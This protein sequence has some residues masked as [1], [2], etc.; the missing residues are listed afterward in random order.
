MTETIRAIA[1]FSGGLD[2]T[3]AVRVVRDQGIHVHALRFQTGFC[4]SDDRGR[5][6]ANPGEIYR[7]DAAAGGERLGVP[8]EVIDIYEEYWDILTS[9]PH[10]YGSMMNP[11]I[12]CRIHMLRVAKEKMAER[13]AR[14]VFTGEVLGQRPMTQQRRTLRLIEKESGLDGLLLRPLSAK[15]LEPTLPEKEG[16]IDREKLFDFSGRGRKGQMRLA[17]E[18]G[19]EEYPAPAGGCCSLLDPV[20]AARLTDL[21]ERLGPDERLAREEVHLLKVGRHFR[22]SPSAKLI[23]ARDEGECRVVHF[24]GRLGWRLEAVDVRGPV[25]LVQGE[26][27]ETDLLTAAGI[28]ASYGDGKRAPAVRVRIERGGVS[29]EVEAA[30]LSREI[31]ASLRIE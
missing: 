3:L 21:L 27:S 28:T 6:H 26:P 5:K 16:W 30:P 7:T 15:L 13:D 18:L 10:G 11:C 31:S 25:A 23:V 2:S 24:H 9:P 20:F 4:L 12:D 1:L 14:F 19:I 22:L 29:R 8:V 17:G